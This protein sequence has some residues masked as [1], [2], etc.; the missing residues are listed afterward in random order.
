[1]REELKRLRDGGSLVR[2]VLVVVVLAIG[3]WRCPRADAQEGGAPQAP[4]ANR[5]PAD[6]AT[7]TPP[8]VRSDPTHK[9]PIIVVGP[10]D[11]GVRLRLRFEP[12]SVTILDARTLRR[13]PDPARL[14]GPRLPEIWLQA[15]AATSEYLVALYD[16]NRRI[17]RTYGLSGR[18][19][20]LNDAVPPGR[21]PQ[22]LSSNAAPRRDDRDFDL[23]MP[24]DARWV[25]FFRLATG[26]GA[27][28]APGEARSATPAI[29]SVVASR[30]APRPVAG[31]K[32]T[33][34]LDL[35]FLGLFDLRPTDGAGAGLAPPGGASGGPPSPGI[36]GIDPPEPEPPLPGRPPRT[37][38]VRPLPLP[39]PDD[40]KFPFPF[41]D[42]FPVHM[43]L[44]PI[45]VTKI[46]CRS[47]EGAY[48]DTIPIRTAG[49]SDQKFDFVILGDGFGS[50]EMDKLERYARRFDAAL[51]DTEP[52]KTLIAENR[53]NVTLV[54]TTSTESGI[55][56][57]TD[58]STTFKTYYHVAGHWIDPY[59]HRS[60][61]PTYMGTDDGCTIWSA[62][63]RAAPFDTVE[64]ILMI[65]N[66]SHDGGSS[67]LDSNIFFMAVGEEVS[68]DF[69]A[70]S[71]HESGH[72][73]ARLLE[74]YVSCLDEDPLRD[75]PN[76]AKNPSPYYVWWKTLARPQDIFPVYGRPLATVFG[77]G[78]DYTAICSPG[79][80]Q[81]CM[82]STDIVSEDDRTKM[83]GLFW[84][85]QWGDR[86][87]TSHAE[88]DPP[89]DAPDPPMPMSCNWYRSMATCRMRFRHD[90]FCP[91]CS[92]LIRQEVLK[93]AP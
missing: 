71:I 90:P 14:H 33:R 24:E 41:A 88:C 64:G 65:A 85:A 13:A 29:G 1:M 16:R 12:K 44:D 92:Y 18:P 31:E 6:A 91:V 45:V 40:G 34:R 74:E 11:P 25:G 48:Q 83:V 30:R 87:A 52:Y 20:Y 77:C 80:G 57:C 49:P 7:K 68:T 43:K 72:A 69:N 73:V 63:E 61:S 59:G 47:P 58:D 76:I 46:V 4:P 27:S 75:H 23:P 84:G 62:V 35:V 22:F 82:P 36:G 86:S 39:P 66:C 19:L 21:G 26:V 67:P 55:T 3:S 15:P 56:Q 70:I 50:N 93:A 81:C 5:P 17:R 37:P 38:P 10:R 89:C 51:T 60:G 28:H 32:V 9:A 53:I 8:E 78:M 42:L 54:R 2:D 79:D